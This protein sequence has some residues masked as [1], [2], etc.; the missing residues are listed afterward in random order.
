[1]SSGSSGYSVTLPDPSRLI[2]RLIRRIMKLSVL[3]QKLAQIYVGLLA[4]T[5]E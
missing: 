3:P 2:F 1:M 5:K 4:N